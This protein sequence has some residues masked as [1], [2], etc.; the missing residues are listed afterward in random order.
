MWPNLQS[1]IFQ[2]SFYRRQFYGKFYTIT[3]RGFRH[4]S[5]ICA[6]IWFYFILFIIP[7]ASCAEIEQEFPTNHFIGFN[8]QRCTDIFHSI[9]FYFTA[10]PFISNI[11]S[12]RKNCIGVI[13]LFFFFFFK[14]RS[15][16]QI[17]HAVRI[18]WTI[19]V[20]V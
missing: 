12:K 14:K 1:T 2:V 9:L 20:L 10:T 5:V 15:L 13:H 4:T 18:V 17:L 7:H 8:N 11:L 16:Q 6:M 3:L 19:Y